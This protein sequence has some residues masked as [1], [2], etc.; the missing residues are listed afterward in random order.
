MLGQRIGIE[1]GREN[2]IATAQDEEALRQERADLAAKITG[3]VAQE[4]DPELLRRSMGDMPPPIRPMPDAAITAQ[5][6]GEE[7]RET[8]QEKAKLGL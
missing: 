1:R 8:L 3:E 6:R 5:V 2:R 7:A 4:T